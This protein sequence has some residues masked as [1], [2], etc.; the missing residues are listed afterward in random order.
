[1]HT[2][3]PSTWEVE[4]GI[5]QQVS[6][7]PEL[8]SQTLFQIPNKPNQPNKRQEAKAGTLAHACHSSI[9]EAKTSIF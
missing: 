2:C 3:I 4:A 5:L 8:Q 7:Q 6:G 1:M 9:Q